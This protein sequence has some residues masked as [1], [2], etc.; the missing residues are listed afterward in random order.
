MA[1]VHICDRCG[2]PINPK[3][4]GPSIEITRPFG[5]SVRELC[6]SCKNDLMEWLDN[7]PFPSKRN[8]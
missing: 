3:Y 6:S 5:R 8:K 2:T 1:T 7:K 4:I